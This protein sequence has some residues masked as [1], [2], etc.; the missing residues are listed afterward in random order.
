MGPISTWNAPRTEGKA[1]NFLFRGAFS[2]L[3]RYYDHVHFFFVHA[4]DESGSLPAA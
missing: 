1:K 2:S 4:A 3:L